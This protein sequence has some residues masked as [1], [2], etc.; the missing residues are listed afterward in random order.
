MPAP[1]AGNVEEDIR[2]ALQR[3]ASLDADRLSADTT[4]CGRVAL[5]GTVSAWAE[6]DEALAAVW[7]APWVTEVDDQ[8]LSL[9]RDLADR[10]ARLDQV[11]STLI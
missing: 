11:R 10:R 6:H 5:V 1:D 7:S 3:N 9:R 8:I 2:E 4:T